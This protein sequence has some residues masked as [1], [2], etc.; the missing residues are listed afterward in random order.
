M[1]QVIDQ[2]LEK[3]SRDNMTANIILMKG[4]RYGEGGGVAAR[5]EQRRLAEEEKAAEE[6]RKKES[7]RSARLAKTN[8]NIT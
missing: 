7:G 8:K 3:N 1:T 6:Q 4:T 5:R 2:C